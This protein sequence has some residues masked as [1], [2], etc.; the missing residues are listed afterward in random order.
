M[1]Q[2]EKG[3][4]VYSHVKDIMKISQRSMAYNQSKTGSPNDVKG[5][6]AEFLGEY[7][8]YQVRPVFYASNYG[9]LTLIRAL[10]A[11]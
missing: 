3:T 6:V 1:T 4:F 5:F 7:S 9:V 10:Q 2:T 11:P 8:S